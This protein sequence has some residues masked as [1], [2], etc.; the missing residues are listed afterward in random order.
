MAFIA[1]VFVAAGRS[2]ALVGLEN[3]SYD[4]SVEYSGISAKNET[5]RTDKTGDHRGGV[6]SRLRVGINATVTEDVKTRV[7]LGRTGGQF[8]RNLAG[9]PG[10]SNSIANEANRILVDNAYLD[11]ENLWG[12][13]ARLGR[14]Y[15]GDANDLVWYIGPNQDDNL[16]TNAIDGLNLTRKWDVAHVDAFFG[17]ARDNDLLPS[18]ANRGTY[19][20]NDALPATGDVNVGNVNVAFPTVIPGGK[21]NVGYIWGVQ[22]ISDT[23]LARGGSNR[24]MIYRAGINGGVQENRFTYRAEY[25]QNGG[26]STIPSATT[27]LKYQGNAIDL[28]VG[29]NSGDTKAGTFGVAVDFVRGSGDKDATNSKDKSFRDLRAVGV[30]SSDRYYGEIFGK[31]N[32]VSF[33][34]LGQGIDTNNQ[35]AGMQILH[36]GVLAKPAAWPKTWASADFYKLDTSE[37]SRTL[38]LGGTSDTGKSFGNEYDFTLGYRHSDNVGMEG[39]YALLDVGKA[40]AGFGAAPV[41][42]AQRD[43]ITKLFA[44]VKVKWGGAE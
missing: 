35:G 24:L 17:K 15:V 7:E 43:N 12:M 3:L 2:W 11:F 41:T 31:S 6:N 37:D 16:T 33:V 20:Q 22:D 21:I 34:P 23:A 29:M 1:I 42:G 8:G 36:I 27:K 39:G 19:R 32:A 14:Q 28:G 44:R 9:T 18:A 4:G 25:L 26:Q 40:L 13:G 5:D 10:A 38:G 30:T